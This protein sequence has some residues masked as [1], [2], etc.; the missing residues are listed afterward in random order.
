MQIKIEI[1]MFDSLSQTFGS[2]KLYFFL[3]DPDQLFKM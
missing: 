2:V 3:K 1:L